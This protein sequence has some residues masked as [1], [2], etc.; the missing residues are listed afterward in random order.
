VA[1]KGVQVIRKLAIWLRL[2]DPEDAKR[3]E[4]AK[5]ILAEAHKEIELS[6]EARRKLLR[7]EADS[8]RRR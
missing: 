6:R 2:L 7:V 4:E 5:N 3:H 1:D 8:V